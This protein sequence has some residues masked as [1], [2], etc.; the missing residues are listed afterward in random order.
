MSSE[1]TEEYAAVE[2]SIREDSRI[3]DD[4]DASDEVHKAAM[5]RLEENSRKKRDIIKKIKKNK[6]PEP[7]DEHPSNI[8]FKKDDDDDDEDD[9]P[10]RF[11]PSDFE[12]FNMSPTGVSGGPRQ[13]KQS[14]TEGTGG[15]GGG[16]G[17][18]KKDDDDFVSRLAEMRLEFEE[19]EKRLGEEHSKQVASLQAELASK[20]RQ[21]FPQLSSD[22][23]SKSDLALKNLL[24]E[25]RFTDDRTKEIS[26][27]F[28]DQID[29]LKKIQTFGDLDGGMTKLT[30]S[31]KRRL[32]FVEGIHKELMDAYKVQGDVL[33]ASVTTQNYSDSLQYR[34][35][36]LVLQMLRG[37]MA[38]HQTMLHTAE[39]LKSEYHATLG[40][41]KEDE[42]KLKSLV[43]EHKSE[44]SMLKS[45]LDQQT[46]K[47]QQLDEE[48][49][50][51]I[52]K[53]DE[54][55]SIQYKIKEKEETMNK[56]INE[57]KEE[58]T[59]V[60]R[61]LEEEKKKSKSDPA[62]VQNLENKIKENEKM[63][64]NLNVS[65]KA[66][67]EQC[68]IQIT[69]ITELSNLL[70]EA[71]MEGKKADEQI[72]RLE[73]DKNRMQTALRA[74]RA[75]ADKQIKDE[76]QKAK[77][78]VWTATQMS[79]QEFQKQMDKNLIE[80]RKASNEKS[81]KMQQDIN[82]LE[83]QIQMERSR[84]RS[85]AAERQQ[86]GML[87]YTI[88]ELRSQLKEQEYIFDDIMKLIENSNAS[89]QIQKNMPLYQMIIQRMQNKMNALATNRFMDAS[90]TFEQNM[91][92]YGRAR[93]SWR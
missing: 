62:K 92:E 52:K 31:I 10:K 55:R 4:P 47:I 14:K 93:A 90:L 49:L 6:P 42:D 89:V 63:M 38:V 19:R 71:A 77:Q 51:S 41:S 91:E 30:E 64:L 27:H 11:A 65:M 17:R 81:L 67:Q 88:N 32:S 56:L 72:R 87:Q 24:N 15:G 21:K 5:R 69:K 75:W 33:L 25:M 68:K 84:S 66:V 46:K 60:N 36:V 44:L 76:W 40:S 78:Y 61:L 85:D 9:D 13:G 80:D 3:L 54:H 18:K 35:T 86:V 16:G 50:K 83:R 8:K 48:N 82:N 7:D 23:M 39:R 45:L 70:R 43:N 20:Q 37:Q 58:L 1:L 12:G 29:H 59:M 57:Q 53:L 34:D 22:Q 2:Q 79:R 26:K 74:E 73:M 28:Q